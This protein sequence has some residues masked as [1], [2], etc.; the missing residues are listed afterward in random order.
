MVHKRFVNS[1]GPASGEDD[2]TDFVYDCA[3]YEFLKKLI[4][5]IDITIYRD[6]HAGEKGN[7]DVLIQRTGNPSQGIES[8]VE[9]I[10]MIG[11]ID[12]VETSWSAGCERN[13]KTFAYPERFD[14]GITDDN[15]VIQVLSVW[16]T[17]EGYMRANP[18]AFLNTQHMKR[19]HTP[20]EPITIKL[21]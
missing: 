3:E 21:S 12:H 7:L 18:K 11:A 8:A 6:G 17:L 16:Y 19:E 2:R 10:P 14:I 1:F 13:Y 5:G 15:R 9:M 20:Q 4:D